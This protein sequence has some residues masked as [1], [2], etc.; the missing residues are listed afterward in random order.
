[1]TGTAGEKAVPVL[2]FRLTSVPC[3]RG[4]INPSNYLGTTSPLINVATS[5][6]GGVYVIAATVIDLAVTDVPSL[7]IGIGIF[8]KLKGGLEAVWALIIVG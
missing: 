6:T 7:G 4:K 3:W 2:F 1:V 5:L 8:F